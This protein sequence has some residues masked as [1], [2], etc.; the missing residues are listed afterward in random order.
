LAR[1]RR[2]SSTS[3]GLIRRAN[4]TAHPFGSTG[5]TAQMILNAYAVLGAFVL[6]LRALLG[7]LVVGQASLALAQGRNAESP[8][9]KKALEDRYY[10]LFLMAI[11]LLVLNVLSWPLF[12]LLLQSYVR[13]W[14]GVMCIYGVTQIGTGSISVSRFLP[15]LVQSLETTKP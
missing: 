3:S 6:A 13:E 11:L 12:Y 9:G 14:P 2:P 5:R 4:D 10:L 8:E 7:L 1:N 15:G